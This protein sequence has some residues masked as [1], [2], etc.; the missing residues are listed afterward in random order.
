VIFLFFR[1]LILAVH[2]TAATSFY[3][4]GPVRSRSFVEDRGLVEPGLRCDAWRDRPA[5]M[6]RRVRRVHFGRGVVGR[7]MPGAFDAF[8]AIR[9]D[10]GMSAQSRRLEVVE[11]LQLAV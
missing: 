5:V 4:I 6:L 8:E 7:E 9:D 1:R 10:L 2:R 11:H 3:A